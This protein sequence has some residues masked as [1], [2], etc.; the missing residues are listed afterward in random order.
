[1]S[2]RAMAIRVARIMGMLLLISFLLSTVSWKD[3][4]T[5]FKTASLPV[6]AVGCSL[7]Y[8]NLLLSCYKWRYTLALEEIQ[9]PF[10]Y[11]V[12]WYMIGA[13]VSNFLP[14][15]IGGD[16]GRGYYA[17]RYTGR[18]TAIASTIVME[19]LSGL[20]AMF[21]L[22]STGLIFMTSFDHLWI[23]GL[24]CVG[25]G[26]LM[27]CIRPIFNKIV[28]YQKYFPASIQGLLNIFVQTG[29]RYGSQKTK[30]LIILILSLV[31]QSLAGVGLWLNLWAV[32]IQLPLLQV[33]LKNA[34]V[35][36][37]SLLPITINGWGIREGLLGYF[38][39]P[40]GAPTAG[41]I[42]AALL[43]RVIVLVLSI[44]GVLFLHREKT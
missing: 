13:F 37:A 5:I 17:G 6:I 21:V 44:P 30:L 35:S 41:I 34:M 14:T 42:A 27:V 10:W 15:E 39:T 40:L 22:A 2:M 8:I 12:R 11:L 24:L 31:F 20:F 26:L 7:Y 29:H 32:S 4:W 9:I 18:V 36:I 16:I 3:I 43:G 25:V 33:I 28:Y 19:R 1:M 38:L 23:V